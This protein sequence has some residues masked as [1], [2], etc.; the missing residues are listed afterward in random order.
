M[1]L[2]QYLRGQA[3]NCLRIARNCFDL[4]SAERLRLLANEL[5]TKANEIERLE[6]VPTRRIGCNV[7]N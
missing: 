4:A 3:E 6:G 5:K 1:P 7:N 2:A